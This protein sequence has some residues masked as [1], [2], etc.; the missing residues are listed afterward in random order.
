MTDTPDLKF[1]YVAEVTL[2]CGTRHVIEF[3]R[4]AWGRNALQRLQYNIAVTRNAQFSIRHGWQHTNVYDVATGRPE[5]SLAIDADA[6]ASI[7]T[8]GTTFGLNVTF[9]VRLNDG[10]SASEP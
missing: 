10:G 5:E 8:I 7:Q 4:T 6:I 2:K 3:P 1:A 9:V